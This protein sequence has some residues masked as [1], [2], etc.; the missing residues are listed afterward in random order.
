MG[1]NAIEV[2]INLGLEK[3][4]IKGVFFGVEFSG[5]VFIFFGFFVLV[6]G[7]EVVS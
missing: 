2:A 4:I 7:G 1:I 6:F 3:V 5:K